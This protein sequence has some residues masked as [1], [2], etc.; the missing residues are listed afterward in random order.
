MS[1]PAM[2]ATWRTK[3][4]IFR[5][6]APTEKTYPQTSA[7]SPAAGCSRNLVSA[8]HVA[9]RK[10]K[11]RFDASRPR[12]LVFTLLTIARWSTVV[13]ALGKLRANALKLLAQQ[14]LKQVVRIEG[15]R[16][17]LAGQTLRAGL[18]A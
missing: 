13:F 10:G 14:H 4:T 12:T 2:P 16:E 1:K 15:T 9:G 6:T 11:L 18:L 7:P 17:A 3:R 8:L 5:N